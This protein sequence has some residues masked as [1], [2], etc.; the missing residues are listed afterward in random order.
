[1][2]VDNPTS[3]GASVVDDI[4][5]LVAL[6][7]PRLDAVDRALSIYDEAVADVE[8]MVAAGSRRG[9]TYYSR[10]ARVSGQMAVALREAMES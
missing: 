7:T 9:D 8:R 5:K 2:T 10:M 4:E 3:V 6:T 1:M